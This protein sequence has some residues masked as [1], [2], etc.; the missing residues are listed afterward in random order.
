MQELEFAFD[1]SP[2]PESELTQKMSWKFTLSNQNLFS[3]SPRLVVVGGHGG[4]GKI[5]F[6]PAAN[7][8]GVSLVFVTLKDS[9]GTIPAKFIPKT[10]SIG[11]DESDEQVFSIKVKA[12]GAYFEMQDH[13]YSA[14]D[15][16]LTTI[17]KFAY[18]IMADITPGQVNNK[19]VNNL[20]FIL[21]SV[22]DANTLS[23]REFFFSLLPSLDLQGTLTFR[24]A[25]G[26][27]GSVIFTFTLYNTEDIED[28]N[29][30]FSRSAKLTLANHAPYFNLIEKVIKVASIS[31]PLTVYQKVLTNISKGAKD[32]DTLQEVTF[33]IQN[34]SNDRIFSQLPTLEKDGSI[35]FVV[36]PRVE[37]SCTVRF[38]SKDNGGVEHGGK[39]KSGLDE[40]IIQIV[41]TN[42]APGFNLFADLVTWVEDS[43]LYTQVEFARNISSGTPDESGQKLHFY[44]TL[45]S[46]SP[47]LFEVEPF[48]DEN[49]TLTFHTAKGAFG[50]AMVAMKITDNGG[51]DFGGKD[52]SVSQPSVLICVLKL[53]CCLVRDI[54]IIVCLRRES[55]HSGFESILDRR[56][57]HYI[58]RLDQLMEAHY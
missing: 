5:I 7:A 11:R 35:L 46:V 50:S 43:G 8:V 21:T 58:L 12:S 49:G 13:I 19:D 52:E 28:G 42:V 27:G 24:P 29:N 30:G 57:F 36:V 56:L 10:T 18:N 33:V 54:L 15:A 22:V 14:A 53:F 9:G 26:V 32:E 55:K 37:G 3:E 4:V 20:N 39:D 2:G 6:Q 48:V 47:N 44:C 51:T 16:G 38:F 41:K 25:F 31:L 1:L 40:L 34:V 23:A 45:L 17:E